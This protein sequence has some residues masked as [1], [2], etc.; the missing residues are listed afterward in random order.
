MFTRDNILV[1]AVYETWNYTY[2][3]IFHQ[4]L[5]NVALWDACHIKRYQKRKFLFTTDFSIQTLLQGNSIWN[6][7]IK[8]ETHLKVVDVKMSTN[9][10]LPLW[11]ISWWKTSTMFT[12]DLNTASTIAWQCITCRCGLRVEEYSNLMRGF[13]FQ[14]KMWYTW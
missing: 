13:Q 12:A 6:Q 11:L 4:V 9:I 10:P 1:F 7:S 8:Y 14:L 3:H 5:I 2:A